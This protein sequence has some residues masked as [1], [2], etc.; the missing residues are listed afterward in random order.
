MSE[1]L[2]YFLIFISALIIFDALTRFIRDSVEKRHFVNYR[3]SLIKESSD[4][5]AVYQTMLKRRRAQSIEQSER[6]SYFSNLVT[7]SGLNLFTIRGLIYTLFIIC[8]S[9]IAL[10]FVGLP[11]LL[12]IPLGIILGFFLVWAFVARTRSTRMKKFVG[13]L[14][15]ALDVIVRSLAAGHPFG[16]SITLVAREMS[17][18]VGTEFGLMSDEMTYGVDVDT[19]TR[20]MAARVGAEELN[21]LAISLSVQQ[22]SGGNLG[23]ILANLSDMIRRRTMMK[24]KIKAISAE[25][26]ATSWVMLV[27]PFFLYGMVVTIRPDYYDPL[28]ESDSAYIIVAIGCV[29][30]TVGMI[31]VRKIVN[32]DY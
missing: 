6:F 17:D 2:I 16:T 20:S 19:A 32:F 26:R 10:F 9:G 24:S 25:G 7:Q 28:W 22:G 23:E 27:F 18:P 4:R 5:K 30:M 14:P 29:I 21:L 1:F 15:D 31:V 8:I 11:P 3:L 12:C 13:Q